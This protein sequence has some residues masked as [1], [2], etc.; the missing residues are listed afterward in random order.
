MGAAGR[1][2]EKFVLEMVGQKIVY[3]DPTF[4]GE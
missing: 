4:G 1:T 2:A 3:R